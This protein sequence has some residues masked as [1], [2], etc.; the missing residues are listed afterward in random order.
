MNAEWE[1]RAACRGLR[2]LFDL[3]FTDHRGRVPNRHER[4]AL[5]VCATCSVRVQCLD[6]ELDSMRL[7][8]QTDGVFGGTI[9]HQRIEILKNEGWRRSPSIT[10]GTRKGYQLHLLRPD[11]FGE[12]CADCRN[13]CREYAARYK[14]D[15]N[16]EE[17]S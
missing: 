7:G 13:A 11:L 15:R 9:V 5:A 16:A 3:T 2:D 1:D 14:A 8:R 6:A 17:A 10:H 4:A 12:P